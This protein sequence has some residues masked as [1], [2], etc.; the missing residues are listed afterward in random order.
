MFIGL[1]QNYFTRP[2]HSKVDA[3]GRMSHGVNCFLYCVVFRN[4]AQIGSLD[5]K[6]ISHV[7]HKDRNLHSETQTNYEASKTVVAK[8]D[9]SSILIYFSR[10]LGCRRI[11]FSVDETSQ[12]V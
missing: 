5:N 7:T 3:T 9:N 10:V 1:L 12:N 2:I 4:C 11:D 6:N 8:S